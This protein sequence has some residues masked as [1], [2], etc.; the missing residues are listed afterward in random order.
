MYAVDDRINQWLTQCGQCRTVAETS[1]KL[2][3]LSNI[4]TKIQLNEFTCFLPLNIKKIVKESEKKRESPDGK[5]SSNGSS[6]VDGK[7][8]KQNRTIVRNEN[9]KTEWKL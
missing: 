9:V 6:C 1:I 5:I 2:I 8:Q 4:V 7:K 3:R